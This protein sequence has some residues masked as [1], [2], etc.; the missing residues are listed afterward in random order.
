MCG[1]GMHHPYHRTLA[2]A[3]LEK[4][5][6]EIQLVDKQMEE[7]GGDKIKTK[8]LKKLRTFS[9]RVRIILVIENKPSKPKKLQKARKKL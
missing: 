3:P 2:N 4:D 1:F 6:N 5:N 8:R 7:G 9:I